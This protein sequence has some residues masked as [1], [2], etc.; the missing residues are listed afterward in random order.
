MATVTRTKKYH[1]YN[2]CK[3]EG[4]PEHEAKLDFQSTSN[5]YTFDNGNGEV[6]HFEEGELQ[7]FIDLLKSLGRADAVDI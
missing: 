6:R 5:F 4:C 1:C 7:V 3:Q 2:D